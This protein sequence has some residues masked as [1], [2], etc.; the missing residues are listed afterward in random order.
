MT[1]VVNIAAYRKAERE[2]WHSR[3]HA[4]PRRAGLNKNERV[5]Y[6]AGASRNTHCVKLGYSKNPI[7]R[8]KS[9]RCVMGNDLQLLA[10]YK[11]PNCKNKKAV[12]RAERALH[13]YLER[14]GFYRQH[15]AEVFG[16]SA[17]ETARIMQA[18]ERYAKRNSWKKMECPKVRSLLLPK[19]QQQKPQSTQPMVD[20]A[21]AA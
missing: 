11:P 12:Q 3:Y 6:V 19:R 10:M 17:Y 9:F 16:R 4:Q 20:F 14:T 21:A 7:E 5:V 18:V 15:K 1:K 8:M 2:R 13:A